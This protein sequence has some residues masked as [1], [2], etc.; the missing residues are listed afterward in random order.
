MSATQGIDTLLVPSGPAPFDAFHPFGTVLS[1]H[2]P[3][4]EKDWGTVVGAI[5]SSAFLPGFVRLDWH[6]VSSMLKGGTAMQ[7]SCVSGATTR[8][9]MERLPD[10]F[11]RQTRDAWPR[12]GLAVFNQDASFKLKDLNRALGRIRLGDAAHLLFATPATQPPGVRMLFG[13]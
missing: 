1:P 9:A 4:N 2:A 11:E 7:W 6:D 5:L 3:G 10:V 8:D 12:R 13:Y